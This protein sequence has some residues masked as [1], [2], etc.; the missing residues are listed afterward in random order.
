MSIIY[1]IGYL[2]KCKILI[3]IWKGEV[4][5]LLHSLGR[6]GVCQ[7]VRER[8]HAIPSKAC[9]QCLM[10]DKRLTKKSQ[11]AHTK[12]IRFCLNLN[13]RAHVGIKEFKDI[14][15]LKRERFE[16]QCTVCPIVLKVFDN[17]A[18]SYK[19]EMLT[20]KVF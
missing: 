3:L 5:D 14:N 12:C 19:S 1:C 8:S 16:Q 2:A 4:C 7:G 17:S 18:P 20:L 10:L 13:N 11:T 15:W 9:M 6:E